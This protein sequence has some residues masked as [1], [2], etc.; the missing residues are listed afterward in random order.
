M[1]FDWDVTK[2]GGTEYMAQGYR[3]KIHPF[4]KNIQHCNQIVSP[5]LFPNPLDL[6]SKPIVSWFHNL[7]GQYS[8]GW[9]EIM[10]HPSVT[11]KTIKYIVPSE[12]SKAIYISDGVNPN[13]L[14]VIPNAIDISVPV[15]IKKISSPIKLV[16]TS[17][18][19][20]GLEMLLLATDYF[21]FDFELSVFGA[22]RPDET[23][24]YEQINPQPWV[25]KLKNYKKITFYGQS[26][27]ETVLKHVS[28][29]D[30]FVY[31]NL[32]LETF[33]LAALEAVAV[34]TKVITAPNGALKEVL[35]NR[36][37]FV[38]FDER[39]TDYINQGNGSFLRTF[40]DK[41]PV[42]FKKSLEAFVSAIKTEIAEPTPS[43]HLFALSNEVK[44]AY[45]W[46]KIKEKWLLLDKE[47][48]SCG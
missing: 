37:T 29:A 13:K 40:I 36:A 38:D 28:E 48:P 47:L 46:E 21:D 32:Y 45:S 17:H 5:G 10:F 35:A 39:L 18:P 1:N 30:I 12:Y 9:S 43:E 23:D 16:Y 27:K 44:E 11:E 14:A 34:G 2:F 3:E 22:F 33:C 20:R 7:S 41:Y 31:P 42:S 15:K 8:Q 26:P 4:T 6:I 19:S 25:K 24:F